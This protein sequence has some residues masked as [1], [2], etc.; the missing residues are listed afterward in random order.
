MRFLHS[1]ASLNTPRVRSRSEDRRVRPGGGSRSSGAPTT[2][3]G[4]LSVAAA[5][6][7]RTTSRL[8]VC[9]SQVGISDPFPHSSNYFRWTNST[10]GRGPAPNTEPGSTPTREVQ[11]FR[12]TAIVFAHLPGISHFPSPKWRLKLLPVPVLTQNFDFARPVSY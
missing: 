5:T 9:G 1:Y 7:R 6:K 10:S 4:S 2:A 12:H 8:T 3:A 11:R